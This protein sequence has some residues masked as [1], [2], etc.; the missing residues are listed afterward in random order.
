MLPPS[1]LPTA[2]QWAASAGH[3]VATTAAHRHGQRFHPH[4]DE[5]ERIALVHNGII[6][7]HRPAC[8]RGCSRPA[9]T[10]FSSET[11]NEVLAHPIEALASDRLA[12]E[13]DAGVKRP[14][15]RR[16]LGPGR[17]RAPTAWPSWRRTALGARGRAGSSAPWCWP[18][19]RRK[20][21]W[22]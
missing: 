16:A 9:G 22:L 3:A 4:H 8:A 7:N 6:E 5:Q 20:A 14:A 2:T 21:S 15:A 19:H 11:D 17:W 18:G 13:A 10:G 12:A 1:W